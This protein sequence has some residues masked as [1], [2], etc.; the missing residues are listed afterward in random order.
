MNF[1]INVQIALQERMSNS[2]EPDACVV[3]LNFK[4]AMIDIS[5]QLGRRDIDS[6]KF[7]CSDFVPVSKMERFK[8]GLDIVQAL[9][10]MCLISQP[11]NVYFLA[12]LLWLIRRLDLLQKLN[13]SQE[14]VKASLSNRQFKH[15]SEY[16][17]VIL[18]TS[19]LLLVVLL[20]CLGCVI[21]YKFCAEISI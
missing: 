10:Q 19:L 11:D 12:E 17:Y 1:E 9:Q 8:S 3:R 18:Q 5:R 4:A 7:L 2:V 14:Y 13:V 15:V 21:L 6:L 20:L 16:R